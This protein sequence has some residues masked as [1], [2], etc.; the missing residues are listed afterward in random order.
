MLWLPGRGRDQAGSGA[1]PYCRQAGNRA[2][3]RGLNS[4]RPH[5]PARQ[6]KHRLKLAGGAKQVK[7]NMTLHK[8]CK[9]S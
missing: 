3:G 4:W 6:L 2:P 5:R 7:L 1:G 9:F 8:T